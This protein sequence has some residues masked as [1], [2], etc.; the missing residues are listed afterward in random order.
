MPPI[1]I[2]KH[3][4]LVDQTG[5]ECNWLSSQLPQSKW[6]CKAVIRLWVV[7]S[8]QLIFHRQ[9]YMYVAGFAF[10]VAEAVYFQA[11]LPGEWWDPKKIILVLT[12]QTVYCGHCHWN[13]LLTLGCR[14]TCMLECLTEIVNVFELNLT[15]HAA[16]NRQ[17]LACAL[18]SWI[19]ILVT[20]SFVASI[21]FPQ[22]SWRTA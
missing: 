15:K 5:Y 10:M 14:H 12:L 4:I 18:T 8:L 21:T 6:N 9:I 20:M 1:I 17:T 2:G 13:N 22:V 7:G 11:H 19:L 3:F 16:K